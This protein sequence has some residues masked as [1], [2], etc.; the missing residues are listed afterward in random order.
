MEKL[1]TFDDKDRLV[2]KDRKVGDTRIGICKHTHQK[3]Q[4][5]FD[6]FSDDADDEFGWMCLHDND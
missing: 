1:Y 6:N 2:Q 4:Q 3:V 5:E